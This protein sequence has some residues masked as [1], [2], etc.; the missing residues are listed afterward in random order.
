MNERTFVIP[1]DIKSIANETLSH[2]IVLSYEA[3]AN[4]IKEID[5]IEKIIN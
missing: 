5:I 3:V 2:R 4:N 1:E